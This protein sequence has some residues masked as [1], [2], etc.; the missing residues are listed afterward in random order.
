MDAAPGW[1][2]EANGVEPEKKKSACVTLD[3]ICAS[4]FLW[5][6]LAAES[7]SRKTSKPTSQS[8]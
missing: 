3:K 2:K 8:R 7:F 5:A 6:A 4:I 1:R